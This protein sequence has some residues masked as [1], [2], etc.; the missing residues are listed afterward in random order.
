MLT[1]RE[2]VLYRYGLTHA[3]RI[4]V[5]TRKQQRMLK[6]GFRLEAIPL[7]M[8][9]PGPAA[10]ECILLSGNGSEPFRV[11]WVGRIAPVKRLEVLLDVAE[12]V[13]DVRFEVAGQPDAA[14]RYT[15]PLIE[16]ARTMQN[17]TLHGLVGRDRMPDF[18]RSAS[19]LCCTS[20]YE[21]FP[22]TFLEAWSYGL[23]IVSTVDPDS[24]ITKRGLGFH[25]ANP[26]QTVQ[27][28][29]RFKQDH[30]L[31]QSMSANA[32]SYYLKYHALDQAMPRFEGILA[33]A[34]NERKWV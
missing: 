19:I 23:P 15:R 33:D 2:R 8:P 17:V 32:R 29:L 27:A 9:C 22:N 24:L 34:L 11:A 5:Q 1:L 13:P 28:I 3:D 25:V 14:E 10:T 16:K 4:V 12:R 6:D 31:R 18:F 20:D 7:P 21:G 30:E 26:Q